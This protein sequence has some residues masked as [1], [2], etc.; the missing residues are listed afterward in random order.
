[1][2]AKASEFQSGEPVTVDTSRDAH[3]N[4]IAVRVEAAKKQE[5]QP[6]K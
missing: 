6:D 1:M 4:L 3:F 2:P 5:R